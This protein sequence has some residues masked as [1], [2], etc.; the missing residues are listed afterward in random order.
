MDL[1]ARM[2]AEGLVDQLVVG[3]VDRNETT[4]T[5]RFEVDG[6]T[7]QVRF[8]SSIEPQ[9]TPS[10]E[11]S[12]A[13]IELIRVLVNSRARV[14]AGQFEY[15]R[16]P[17]GTW[18]LWRGYEYDEPS[19]AATPEFTRQFGGEQFDHALQS[20]EWLGLDELRPMFASAFGD[21][22]L[23]SPDG[24]R[25]LD[26]VDGTLTHHWHSLTDCTNELAT[27]L[28]SQRYLRAD[29]ATEL[30]AT[31]LVPGPDQIYDFAHPPVFGGELTAANIQVMDF[32]TAVGMAGQ[33]HDQA[34]FIPEGAQVSIVADQPSR[35]SRWR[36][37]LGRK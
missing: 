12:A 13:L 34:R 16:N 9:L 28:G 6:T 29:L 7:V 31:G 26:I 8:W 19:S 10:A 17:D 24:V 22:F 37:L 27:P 25:R 21:I 11:L 30:A 15:T 2:E 5:L 33:I 35:R 36:K 14:R 4:A 18:E 32:V 20:W 1:I 3:Q 23:D